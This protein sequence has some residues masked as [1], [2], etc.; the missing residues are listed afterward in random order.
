MGGR[1][2]RGRLAGMARRFV[3]D[4]NPLRRA[5]DRMEGA[6]LIVLTVAFL[7]GAPLAAVTAASWS[8]AATRAAER[9]EAGWQ[10]VR[11]VVLPGQR[12]VVTAM[13]QTSADARMKARWTAPDGTPRAGTIYVSGHARPGR[14]VPVWTN[15]AGRVVGYPLHHSDL[16]V[17]AALWAMLA[18]TA[19]GAVAGGCWLIVRRLLDRRR[20]AGWDVGW[21]ATGPEWTRRG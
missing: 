14:V 16:V 2:R 20:L 10:Q 13:G 8:A 9:A 18:V 21:A 15:Q 5:A 6:L 12:Q 7:A 19:T 17:R 1:V 4:R 11:A 3:P